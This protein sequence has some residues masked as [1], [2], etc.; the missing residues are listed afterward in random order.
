MLRTNISIKH[1]INIENY[2]KLR[3]YLKRKSDGYKSK[4]SKILTAIDVN[5]FLNEA[6]DQDFLFMKV[7]LIFGISGACR[8]QELKNIKITD[9][10]NTGNTLIIKI[11]D[12]K[13]KIPRSFIISGKFYGICKNYIELR[14]LIKDTNIQQFFLN[15]QK[16]KVTRQVVGINKLGAVP[17]NIAEYLKLPN[18]ALYTGHCFRRT[19]ATILVDAGGDLMALK[20]HGGWKSSTVAENY[21]DESIL[22]KTITSNR[23]LHSVVNHSASTSTFNKLPDQE[24]TT[25]FIPTNIMT[26]NTDLMEKSVAP[27]IIKN[28]QNFTIN[29]NNK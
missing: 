24:E 18:A 29:F 22:N 23:I 6:P 1:N 7:V 2:H 11:P 8:K 13:T 9:I 5:K 15:F 4:K 21:V 19:S 3:A 27:I 14:N 28:C 26:M 10:E 20:R 16:G 25:E 12:T 17:K